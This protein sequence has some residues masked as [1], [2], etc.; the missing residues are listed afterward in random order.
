M[1]KILKTLFLFLFVLLRYPKVSNLTCGFHVCHKA[2]AGV[3]WSISSFHFKL[4]TVIKTLNAP[5]LHVTLPALSALVPTVISRADLVGDL[6]Y[7]TS[8]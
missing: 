1:K 8:F 2:A 3:L 4:S 7:V 6:A 5:Y